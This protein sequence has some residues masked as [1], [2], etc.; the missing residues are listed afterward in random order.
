ML[1]RLAVDEFELP[2]TV[3]S[4]VGR[5]KGT[6]NIPAGNRGWAVEWKE[7]WAQ[8]K[9]AADRSKALIG[10]MAICGAERGGPMRA[11]CHRRGEFRRRGAQVWTPDARRALIL[12]PLLGQ[13]ASV[14]ALLERVAEIAHVVVNTD[15]R[16]VISAYRERL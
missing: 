8:T 6:R 3:N 1:L 16:S 13:F 5:Q 14:V 4:E 9:M 10:I 7:G 11:V 15:L 2:F 12:R